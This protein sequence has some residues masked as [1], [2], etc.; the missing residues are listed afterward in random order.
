MRTPMELRDV[1][2][3]Y[4][5]ASITENN[6]HFKIRL[7]RH[8]L[9]LAMLADKIEREEAEKVECKEAAC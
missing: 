4:R 3:L 6:R 5:E 8:A 9:D 7:A 1:S 2:R